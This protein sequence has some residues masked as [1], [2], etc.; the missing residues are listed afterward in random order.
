MNDYDIFTG[1]KLLF[2]GEISNSS[3]LLFQY[4]LEEASMVA[5]NSP[6]KLQV[7]RTSQPPAPSMTSS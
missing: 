6:P 5:K 4:E 1:S 7:L 2:R 3:L